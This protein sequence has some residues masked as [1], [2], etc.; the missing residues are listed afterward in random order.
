MSKQ[1]KVN[2]SNYVQGGRLTPDE[3][4]RERKQQAEIASHAKGKE[5]VVARA[6]G[7]TRTTAKSAPAGAPGATRRRSAPEE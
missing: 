5:R 4:A 2:K 1:N 3:M 7:P 6:P